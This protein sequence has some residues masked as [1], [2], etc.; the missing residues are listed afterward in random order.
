MATPSFT[1]NLIRHIKT[2]TAQA[3]GVTV[4]QVLDVSR[5]GERLAF[6]SSTGSLWVSEGQGDSWQTVSNHLPPVRCVRFEY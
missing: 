5:D 3:G 4:Q 6:G 1:S 2:P